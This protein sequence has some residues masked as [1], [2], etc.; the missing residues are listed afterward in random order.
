MRQIYFVTEGVT[1]QIMLE[2]LIENWLD[3]EDFLPIRI[4]PPS[5][6]YA[7]AME[8]TLSQGWRGVVAWCGS[9]TESTKQ[10]REE[11]LIKADLLVIHVD[12]DVARDANFLKPHFADLIPP[13]EPLCEHVRGGLAF[14]FGG[15]AR[16]GR[17]NPSPRR[18]Q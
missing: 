3:N 10:S 17:N 12:A 4:Q 16:V 6:A 7:D 13:I 18:A 2:G 5:S 15:E 1:D 9:Q 11:V 14:H 8:T